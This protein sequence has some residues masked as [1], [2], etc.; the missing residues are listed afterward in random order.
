MDKD[1]NRAPYGG[2]CIGGGRG[3]GYWGI[4]IPL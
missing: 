4:G 2:G 3:G 1:K